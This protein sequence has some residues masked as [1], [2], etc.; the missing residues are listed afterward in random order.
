M[1]KDVSLIMHRLLIKLINKRMWGGKHTEYRN[2]S[3]G[4]PDEYTSDRRGQKLIKKA[5]KELR[6]EGFLL[7]KPSTGEEHFSLNPRAV[8][9]IHEFI[10]KV[11]REF[12]LNR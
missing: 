5:I 4:L 8:K 12:N 7:S 1:E 11:E 3:K 9:E 10:R 6:N 2:L